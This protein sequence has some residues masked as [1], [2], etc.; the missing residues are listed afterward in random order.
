LQ[1]ACY[2]VPHSWNSDKLITPSTLNFM[3][4]QCVKN[5]TSLTF[6]G[7]F[8]PRNFKPELYVPFVC[9]SSLLNKQKSKMADNWRVWE[10]HS[11]ASSRVMIFPIF[12]LAAVCHILGFLKL[13]LSCFTAMNFRY[14]FW[15]TVPNFAETDNIVAKISRF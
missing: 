13:N 15:S 6:S 7:K 14:T 4:L 5:F 9:T 10:T 1:K 12:K 8:L 3:P 11:A 2:C